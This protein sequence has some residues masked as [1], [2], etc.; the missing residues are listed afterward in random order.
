MEMIDR[1]ALKKEFAIQCSGRCTKCVYYNSVAEKGIESHCRLIDIA[2]TITVKKLITK[3][4]NDLKDTIL[5]R[6]RPSGEWGRGRFS[7]CECS[8]C[9]KQ[10]LVDSH[11]YIKTD[12]CPYCGADMRTKK[13]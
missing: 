1:D 12:F 7:L 10:P 5:N 3:M 13:K 2:P 6:L 8:N 4:P 11:G 9:H